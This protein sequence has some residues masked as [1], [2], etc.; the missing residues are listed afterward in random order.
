M[1][2]G[3]GKENGRGKRHC[4]LKK[5]FFM[6]S[7]VFMTMAS[8]LKMISGIVLQVMFLI[9]IVL[10]ILGECFLLLPQYEPWAM[11]QGCFKSQL[12]AL[13]LCM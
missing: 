10:K 1:G 13:A 2:G 12:K 5:G 7:P 11:S 9:A 4:C 8:L 3:A 6:T